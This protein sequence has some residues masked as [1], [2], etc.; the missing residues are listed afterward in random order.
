MPPYARFYVAGAAKDNT[1]RQGLPSRTDNCRK[2]PLFIPVVARAKARDTLAPF[3]SG[4]RMHQAQSH[5][6]PGIDGDVNSAGNVISGNLKGLRSRHDFAGTRPD[7]FPHDD[8][9]TR[10]PILR[11]V[12]AKVHASA[13]A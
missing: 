12:S 6:W 7:H 9:R 13:G 10:D 8:G 2:Q 1:R 5:H 4:V 3:R 11:R